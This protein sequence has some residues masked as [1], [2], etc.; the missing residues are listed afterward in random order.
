MDFPLY[1]QKEPDRFKVIFLAYTQ[2]ANHAEIRNYLAHDIVDEL[3]ST[4]AAF[5]VTLGD[6]IHQ[7]L[8]L[9][10]D[11]A[12]TI[13]RIGVPWYNIIGNHD[14]NVDGKSSHNRFTD[15]S[16]ERVFGPSHYSFDYGRVHFVALNNIFWTPD[17]DWYVIRLDP[18]QMAFLHNDLA[19]VPLEQLVVLLMHIPLVEEVD[20][21]E[22]Y[23]LLETR[24]N[25]FSIS[26]HW[27]EQQHFLIGKKDNWNGKKPHHHL[28]N[29]A[30]CGVLWMGAPDEAGIP[31]AMSYDGVPNGYSI[32]SFD[33]STYSIGIGG[34]PGELSDEHYAR[35]N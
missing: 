20:R 13:G 10:E 29:V 26:G 11:T 25:T 31:H 6:I 32:A 33:G 7:D 8:S 5:G 1:P 15:E 23:R 28:T 12:E 3:A 14:A 27:H 34:A 19:L 22:I 21:Q 17:S 16:F 35:R 2:C 24:P 18:D 30:A 4:D 9:F